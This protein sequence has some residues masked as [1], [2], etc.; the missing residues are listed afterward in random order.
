VRAVVE[1]YF[2]LYAAEDLDGLISLWSE[3]SP[4]YASLKQNLQRQ[5][6]TEDFSFSDPLIS[7]VKVEIEKAGLR[8]MTN[9]TAINLKNNQKREQRIVRNFAFV[10]E[11]GQW[12]VWRAVPAED[13]LAEALAKAKTEAEGDRLL[14]EEKDLVTAELVRALGSQ[15]DRLYVQGSFSQALAIYTRTQSI[16]EQIGDQRGIA[17]A[18]SDIGNIHR[19]QGNYTQALE[20][21]RK[22]K[23]LETNAALPAH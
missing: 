18:L 21:Y 15:G 11:D 20:Y 19:S 13:D 3:K 23:F 6:T 4:D 7:R 9:L 12:K 5:F 10:K 1:K 8:V 14:I 17:S 22:C 16:A 2:V